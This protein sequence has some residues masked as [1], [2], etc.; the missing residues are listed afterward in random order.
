VILADTGE[1]EVFCDRSLIELD[2]PGDDID[3][4][5]DLQPLVDAWTAPY[6]A[7]DEKHDQA[8]FEAEVPADRRI[9]ARGI[10]VGHI[11]YF[12]TKYSAPMGAVVQLA[13]GSQAAAEMGSYGIGVSR[14]VAGIIEASHD[15]AGIIWP[16]AVAPFK[17]GLINLKSGDEATDAAC[18]DLYSRLGDAGIDVLYDD[19]DERAGAKFKSMDL[20]GLPWQ[21]IVGPRGLAEG[22]VEIKRRADGER[23]TLS[24][25][26]ALEKLCG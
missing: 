2:L 18:E 3:Y 17:V 8:K 16:E 7:T 10:E 20:I 25:E 11:F 1:S 21:L 26:A 9:S 12:G 24:P 19:T 6:A 23:M 5:G 15:E 14:L 4:D 13:D 22:Q